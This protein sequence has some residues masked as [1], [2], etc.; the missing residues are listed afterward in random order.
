M[1]HSELYKKLKLDHTAK[2][3]MHKP[4]SV[5]ENETHKILR[6]VEIQT[7]HLI[8]TKR[9]GLTL[10]NKKKEFFVLWTLPLQQTTER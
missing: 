4:E 1:I 9:P 5:L 6:D 3:Y 2:W 8:P 7:D 10:I